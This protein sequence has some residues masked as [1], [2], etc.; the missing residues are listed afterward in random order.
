MKI[1]CKPG[2][3]EFYSQNGDAYYTHEII[4]VEEVPFLASL[5]ILERESPESISST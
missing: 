1:S 3:E 4:F 5:K 2:T